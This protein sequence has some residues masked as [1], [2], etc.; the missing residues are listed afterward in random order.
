[1]PVSE[2]ALISVVNLRSREVD[3]AALYR[4]LAPRVFTYAYR[5][6]GNRQDA[7]DIT[8]ETFTRAMSSTSRPLGDSASP[9][10]FTI[11]RNLIID[12]SRRRWRLP[13][14]FAPPSQP[15]PDDEI[16]LRS[17]LQ[18]LSPQAR[19]AILLRLVAGLSNAEVGAI[20]GKNPAA[21][22]MLVHRTLSRLRR[23][24]QEEA[25]E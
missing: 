11:A 14:L 23:S 15:D 2:N 20:L 9:W 16:L 7:E 8:S 24:W 13:L 1:M 18:G 6:V 25:A 10:I 21:V 5:R 22:K 12:R 4:E 19:D 3:F 17:M